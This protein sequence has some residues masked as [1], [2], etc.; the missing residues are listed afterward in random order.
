MKREKWNL[1][2][3]QNQDR[4]RK[5]LLEKLGSKT[6]RRTDWEM[7][8]Q[9]CSYSAFR[10]ALR[11]LLKNKLVKRI[12]RGVYKIT[13]LGKEQLNVWRKM[14]NEKSSKNNS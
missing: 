5:L 8:C 7:L 1:R 10:S 9:P 12:E 4:F 6:L 2:K 3:R 13:D 14:L 11:Y